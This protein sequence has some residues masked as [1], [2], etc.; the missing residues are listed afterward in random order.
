[1]SQLSNLIAA[2]RLNYTRCV[3]H[4]VYAI[5]DPRTDRIIYIGQTRNLARRRA[6]HLDGTDTL[7]GLVVRQIREN[8][9]VPLVVRLEDCADETAALMA[10]IFWIELMKARGADLANAQ[11][12]TGQVE[13][14]RARRSKSRD[15]AAMQAARLKAIANGA[16]ARE[17]AAWSERD[18]ARLKGMIATGMEMA[19]IADALQ[20]SL[21]SV[22]RKVRLLRLKPKRN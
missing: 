16:P 22:A 10:E 21:G 3:S 11:A 5:V 4:C 9:F 1:M 6:E 18:V 17:T 15:L 12:F 20:R 2:P 19:A 7:S 14:S 13:R 8:G